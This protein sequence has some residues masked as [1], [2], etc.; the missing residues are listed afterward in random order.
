MKSQSTA[1]I[2]KLAN[3]LNKAYRGDQRTFQF[4]LFKSGHVYVWVKFGSKWE[5]QII[6]DDPDFCLGASDICDILKAIHTNKN[7]M[8]DSLVEDLE[9]VPLW[10]SIGTFNKGFPK[11]CLDNVLKV[12]PFPID[13]LSLPY[14]R[15]NAKWLTIKVMG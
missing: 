3:A 11:D 10:V 15:L 5:L 1:I 14:L 9:E 12:L 7:Y 6:L 8:F 13:N 2:T 4:P